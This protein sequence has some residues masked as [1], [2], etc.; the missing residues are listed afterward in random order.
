MDQLESLQT[1]KVSGKQRQETPSKKS[2]WTE[3]LRIFHRLESQAKKERLSRQDTSHTTRES[4]TQRETVNASGGR[5]RA[6][7]GRR[8]RSKKYKEHV[9]CEEVETRRNR[10]ETEGTD[11]RVI[12]SERTNLSHEV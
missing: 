10:K 3:S 11:E 6:F 4:T 7:S 8:T 12:R 1:W 2:Y 5:K 9:I